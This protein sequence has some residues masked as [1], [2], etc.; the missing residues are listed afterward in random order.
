SAPPLLLEPVILLCLPLFAIAAW[1]AA[2]HTEPQRAWPI[3]IAG[4]AMT[5]I[6]A[7]S[8]KRITGTF[9]AFL[10]DANRFRD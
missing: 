2:H 7:W 3:L 4:A 1:Q 5:W 9:H 10:R 6:A 8:W